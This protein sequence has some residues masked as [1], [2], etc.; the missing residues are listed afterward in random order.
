MF[1]VTLWAS[2]TAEL[3]CGGSALIALNLVARTTKD[4]DVLAM[5]EAGSLRCARPL[6]GWLQEDANAVRS[7]LSLP[8]NW[9]NNEPADES[10]FRL[11]LPAGFMERLVPRNFGPL[12]RVSFISRYDQIH[13]K[14]YAAADQGG[15]HFTDLGK[16]SPTK[17]E[18]IAA[19]RWTFTQDASDAFRQVVDEVFQ[20][21]GHG[22]F[23]E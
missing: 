8:E 4:V 16:L 21:L 17:D 20:A 9:L 14:L 3:V 23:H 2:S 1:K 10:L 13:F 11:G 7:E 18:L 22:G 6:P 5:V 12:L 19:A 15:R